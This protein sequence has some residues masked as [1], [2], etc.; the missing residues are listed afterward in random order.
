MLL[1]GIENNTSISVTEAPVEAEEDEM[2]QRADIV[3]YDY[4]GGQAVELRKQLLQAGA[5]VKD[6][7]SAALETVIETI[8]CASDVK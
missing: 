5:V 8:K 4:T 6:T 1:S 2:I 7:V 3:A